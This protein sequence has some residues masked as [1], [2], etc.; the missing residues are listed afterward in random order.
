M[1]A[2]VIAFAD[3][4]QEAFGPLGWMPIPDGELHRFHVPGDSRG[5]T[6]G[7]YV[8]FL[9]GIPAGVYGTWK[10]GKTRR[11]CARQ[12]ASRAEARQVAERVRLA[13]R[14][15]EA[16]RAEAQRAAAERAN[17]IWP[18]AQPANPRH[19]YLEGKRTPPYQT[20]QNGETLWIPI[21]GDGLLVNLQQITPDG[22]KRFLK[23]GR[24]KGCY[25][26]LGQPEPEK[27]LYVCEGF[28]TGATIHAETGAAVACAMTAQNLLSVGR[29]L[30]Q[31]YPRSSLI[32]A[33]DDDRK[34]ASEGKGNAGVEC[35]T[36][37]AQE[38]GCAL[39][40]PDFPPEAP[41]ELSDFNDLAVWRATK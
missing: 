13:I 34:A 5:T 11:W 35:A 20:R 12:P 33:G 10:D 6:N 41:L 2:S 36:K 25:S 21:Y 30:R 18:N 9:D 17:Q 7:W 4:L 38:L 8:L 23:G 1:S 28:A 3:V 19:F 24:I 39:V 22:K 15:R 31:R 40:L 14:Q 37:A 26:P 16:A 29:Y 32:I 27:P